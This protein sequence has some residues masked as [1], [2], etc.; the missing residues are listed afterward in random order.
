M[1]RSDR[2]NIP[3]AIF[4]LIVAPLFAYLM[5]DLGR[6]SGLHDGEANSRARTE[7]RDIGARIRQRCTGSV[8]FARKECATQTV[9]ATRERQRNE[10]N[11][12]AQRDAARWAFWAAIIAALQIPVGVF[13][14]YALLRSLRQTEKSLRIAQR[15]NARNTTRFIASDNDTAKALAHAETTAIAAMEQVKIAG[16]TARKQLRAYLDFDDIVF[17]PGVFTEVVSH[18]SFGVKFKVCNFGKTPAQN[19]VVKYVS[20]VVN[21][22]GTVVETTEDK[23]IVF[24][25]IAPTDHTTNRVFINMSEATWNYIGLN[26][27]KLS[28]LIRVE[29][30]DVFDSH[31]MLESCFESMG[32]SVPFGFVNDSRHSS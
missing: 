23:Q 20:K 22:V 28:L 2:S 27:F 16:D 14:L 4:G 30:F 3:A 19:V 15:E 31:H 17:I 13:G 10:Y 6:G 12:Q 7:Q 11:L 9:E 5:Y 29:Y 21:S 26:V 18:D 8:G 25:A 1:P 32:H 24:G